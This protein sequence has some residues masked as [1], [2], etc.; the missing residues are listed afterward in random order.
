MNNRHSLIEEVS[1]LVNRLF[2][3]ELPKEYLFHNDIHTFEV[4]AAAR[5]IASGMGLCDE[6]IEIVTIA[7][8]FH[9][10]GYLRS[11]DHHEDVSIEIATEFLR[12]SGYPENK[13][14]QV[15]CCIDATR[16]G[17]EPGN[18]LCE[19]L[20]DADMSH[21]GRL[22]FFHR[23]KLLREE[24]K[25]V[26]GRIYTELEWAHMQVEFMTSV[27][28]RTSYAKKK[29]TAQQAAN[30][31]QLRATLRKVQKEEKLASV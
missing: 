23:S 27:H 28:F 4:V 22:S 17:S 11:Y 13:I 30:L 15:K 9:D 5:E 8:W 21:C 16:M 3:Y 24:W 10:I 2:E 12:K 31:N 26:A 20:C 25:N 19:I 14:A 1:T 6:E 18:P 29:F 7:A